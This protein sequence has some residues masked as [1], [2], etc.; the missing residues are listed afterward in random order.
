MRLKSV[1]GPGPM[2]VYTQGSL[3]QVVG[4]EWFTFDGSGARGEVRLP[5]NTHVHPSW[6]FGAEG[7]YQVNVEQSLKLKDGRTVT[8]AGTLTF[9]VGGAGNAN[10]GHY[11][12]GPAVDPNGQDHCAAPAAG[13][14]K[15]ADT[16]TTVF[17]VPGAIFGLGALIFG[18]A[19]LYVSR[20]VRRG[21]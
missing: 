4:E 17:T 1:T 12:F 5:L 20:V 15:L 14:G 21:L 19:V 6:L 13:S 8:G 3:G 9:V 10:D 11:D 18:A 7:T 16:G 2:Y